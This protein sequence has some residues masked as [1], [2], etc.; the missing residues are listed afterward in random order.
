MPTHAR[1]RTHTHIR[2]E[3]N[4]VSATHNHNKHVRHKG[5]NKWHSWAQVKI[6]QSSS[7]V[8]QLL[9]KLQSSYNKLWHSSLNGLIDSQFQQPHSGQD[10]VI[11]S[12]NTKSKIWPLRMCCVYPMLMCFSLNTK[13]NT[14][15]LFCLKWLL[16]DCNYFSLCPYCEPF[17][18]QDAVIAMCATTISDLV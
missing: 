2:T 1:V 18:Q 3:S 4:W 11:C 16:I 12:W 15:F 9:F 14:D 17:S 6:I 8:Q 7:E 10:T 13:Q 5:Q